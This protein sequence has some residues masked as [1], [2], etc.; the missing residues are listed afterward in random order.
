M[1]S[2]GQ[3]QTSVGYISSG[4]GLQLT[5]SNYGV[6]W[7]IQPQITSSSM[8]YV[9]LSSSGQFQTITTT[10]GGVYTS[11]L[12]LSNL[13]VANN[14]Y[15]ATKGRS[16]GTGGYVTIGYNDP[17]AQIVG[18]T[19]G[20]LYV[21]G[22]IYAA[23]TGSTGYFVSIGYST[24]ADILANTFTGATG[25]SLYVKGNVYAQAFYATSDYRIK[26]NIVNLNDTY[27][28]NKMRPV[29]Y[30]NSQQDKLDI[31]LIAHELQEQYPFLVYGEKD[32]ETLQSINY[33]GVVGILV[34]ETQY[35]K[36]EIQ[37]FRIIK[38]YIKIQK[39]LKNVDKMAHQHCKY[40]RTDKK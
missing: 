39:L 37:I 27:N 8:Y 4:G 32:G 2:S 11:S 7:V 18:P 22:S 12:P 25:N 17:T 16:G 21:N 26:Q 9:A 29:L 35:L 23:S 34:K 28:V 6:T 14:V 38:F 1:T 3:Y 40:N 19:G 5:S 10:G 30:K 15:L 24:P 33:N 36:E 13:T 31:G 20:N